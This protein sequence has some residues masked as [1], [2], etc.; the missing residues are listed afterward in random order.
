MLTGVPR[1][2]GKDHSH[3]S[4]RDM[5]RVLF[6][7]K[8]L[9]V[10]FFLTVM[11]VVFVVTFLFPKIYR[12]EASLLVKLGRESVMIDPTVA[13]GRIAEVRQDRTNEINSELQIFRS[14]DL[15][16]TVVDKLGLETFQ[17]G[18][19]GVGRKNALATRE[20]LGWIKSVKSGL[21]KH[22]MAF[23]RIDG[24]SEAVRRQ[25]EKEET[26]DSLM[27]DVVVQAVPGSDVIALSYDSESP[28]MAQKVLQT[29]ISAYLDKHMAVHRTS[30]S[31]QFFE[32]QSD[33]VKKRI[34]DASK[35]LNEIKNK[36]GIASV[37]KQGTLLLER[38]DALK[39][40]LQ[41]TEASVAANEKQVEALKGKLETCPKQ[42]CRHKPRAG[43]RMPSKS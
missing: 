21:A 37:E 9:F 19:N 17:K 16:Q 34:E 35:S 12:S 43:L 3:I 2:I 30:G 15:Y 36:T 4:L 14:R 22:L 41:D 27:K 20:F 40:N 32:Q 29:L 25:K 28:E 10:L 31:Y 38:I 26:I 11:A 39:R 42:P 33:K 18:H 24:D 6:R 23:L 13:V 8:E 1:H 7:R 5:V